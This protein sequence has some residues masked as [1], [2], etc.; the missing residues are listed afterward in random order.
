M[1]DYATDNPQDIPRIQET[2]CG[3]IVAVHFAPNCTLRLV[4]DTGR[5]VE[6]SPLG[7]GA[8]AIEGFEL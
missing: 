4:Y 6:L 2:L 5:I 1:K 3:T 7:Y 8:D